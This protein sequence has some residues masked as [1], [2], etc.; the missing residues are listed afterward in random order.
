MPSSA[1][2]VTSLVRKPIVASAT[3]A[4]TVQATISSS[5]QAGFERRGGAL[6]ALRAIAIHAFA[7]DLVAFGYLLGG[8]QHVPVDLGLVLDQPRVLEHVAIGLV[9]HARDA[10]DAAGD[11]HLG[12]R[13]R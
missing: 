12:T 3:P 1:L 4:S 13:R 5:K 11:Q 8:L 10:F 7:V 9:L 2:I 6:L